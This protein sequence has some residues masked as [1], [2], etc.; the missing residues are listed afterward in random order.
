[1]KEINRNVVRLKIAAV[2]AAGLATVVGAIESPMVAL[3]SVTL[4]GIVI[5]V[6]CFK[7]LID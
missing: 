7:S 6:K 3:Y 4:V 5:I 1:M 2:L